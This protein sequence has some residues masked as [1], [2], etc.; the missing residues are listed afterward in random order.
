LNPISIPPPAAVD[1]LRNERRLYCV[2]TSVIAFD[3]GFRN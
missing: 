2:L 3:L 1:I